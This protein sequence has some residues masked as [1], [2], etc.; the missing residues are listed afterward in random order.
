MISLT[1]LGFAI[2]ITQRSYAI[3][4]SRVRKRYQA[5]PGRQEWVTSVECVCADGTNLSP[6][7]IFKGENLMSNWIPQSVPNSWRFSCNSKGWTSNQHGQE[8]LERVFEPATREKANGQ[9]RLLMDM[10][11]IYRQSLSVIALT[12][13]SMYYC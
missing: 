7:I 11:V 8:W 5:Q 3:V 4:D 2:G 10:I 9:T 12:I 6:F 1:N 13:M